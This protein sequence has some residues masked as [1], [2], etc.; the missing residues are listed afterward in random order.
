MAGLQDMD[1]TL[2]RQYSSAYG[3]YCAGDYQ[4]GQEMRSAAIRGTVLWSFRKN[5][6]GPL[7]YVVDNDS[8][9]PAEV[10]ASDV[11]A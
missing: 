9:W 11:L 4:I 8:G 3:P 10:E 5:G 7:A 1:S 2:S 6:S